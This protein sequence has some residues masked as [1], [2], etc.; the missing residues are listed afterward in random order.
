M[1]TLRAVGEAVGPAAA[2]LAWYLLAVAPDPDKVITPSPGDMARL[3]SLLEAAWARLGP[4][5]GQARQ[6]LVVRP[7]GTPADTVVLQGALPHFLDVLR[8]FVPGVVC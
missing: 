7:S 2:S 5:V 3:W 4:D 8:G 1:V 6:A